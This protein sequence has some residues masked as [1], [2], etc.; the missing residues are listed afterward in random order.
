MQFNDNDRLS[1]PLVQVY[2]EHMSMILRPSDPSKVNKLGSHV[3]FPEALAERIKYKIF[4]HTCKKIMTDFTDDKFEHSLQGTYYI[5]IAKHS[6]QQILPVDRFTLICMATAMHSKTDQQHMA[7]CELI[8]N[9]WSLLHSKVKELL[10]RNCKKK[11]MELRGR[12]LY[13]YDCIVRKHACESSKDG[14]TI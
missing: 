13:L 7:S 12:P 8:Q 1:N 5:M 2:V 3:F 4:S 14:A 6:L 10:V 9:G 11:L